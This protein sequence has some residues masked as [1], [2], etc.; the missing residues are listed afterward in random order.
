MAG[1]STIFVL[2]MLSFLVP[3][4]RA[5]AF[6]RFGY[7]G[8]IG[9]D[10]WGSLSPE[11]VL[12]SKGTHQSPINI[13]KNDDVVYNPKLEPLER[14]YVAVD[15]NATL[16]DNGF[17]IALQYDA[18]V[19]A[20]M[21]N[22]KNYTLKQMHWHSP[23]EHTINGERFA[24]EL[25]L[26]HKSDDGNI[27]VVAILY[28]YGHPDPLLYQ[29][30]DKVA[31]LTKEVGSGD[32][33]AHVAI[34]AMHISALRRRVHKYFR[35]VGSLTTPPC[36]ENVIWNVV[37]KVREMS[38]KQAEALRAPLQQEYRRN[39]RPIQP[40]NGRTVELYD[41]SGSVGNNSD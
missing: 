25:H 6:V 14:D 40:L 10:K 12:C 3:F 20:L 5:R 11:F 21:V 41:G 23:S 27:S 35:Y 4:A 29:I 9:P 17:N 39:S 28:K 8:A 33:E 2:L 15:S 18:S 31:E 32:E 38:K 37:S 36:T 26:V 22:G 7:S 34:G 19:G 24:V 16:V 30:K 13:A 1:Q